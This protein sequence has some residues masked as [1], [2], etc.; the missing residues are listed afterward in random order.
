LLQQIGACS[1][2]TQQMLFW[3]HE[4]DRIG[5]C[6]CSFTSIKRLLNLLKNS[7]YVETP[8]KI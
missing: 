2:A 3:D 7:W 6:Y 8:D 4:Q 5:C 1:V